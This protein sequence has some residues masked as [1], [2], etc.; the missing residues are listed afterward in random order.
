MQ[1]I[2]S[3]RKARMEMDELKNQ[4]RRLQMELERKERKRSGEDEALRKLKKQEEA[5]HE[6]KRCLDTKKQ[7][8][9]VE[10]L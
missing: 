9:Y 2:S 1:L 3:E 5:N 8:N 7:V 6:L 4:M 10:K